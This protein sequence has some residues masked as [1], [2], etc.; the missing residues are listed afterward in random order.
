MKKTQ[1]IQ[2]DFFALYRSSQI[3]KYF[4]STSIAVFFAFVF[5]SSINGWIDTRGLMAS[6]ASVTEAPRLEAD[7]IMK[8]EWEKLVF[9]FWANAKKVD[10]IEFLLLSDP[11]KF[12]SLSSNDSN[13][14][15]TG[16]WEIGT[17]RVSID[18]QGNNIASGMQVATLI[19]GIDAGVPIAIT[20][21]EFI[22]EWQRY[23]LTSKGE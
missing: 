20:D 21:S 9:T 10:R 16:Q 13:V 18:L 17:Y 19:A 22:S 6:V 3:R 15:V 7:L 4:F 2:T 8:R 11:T 12:R 14:T 5:V 1:K 23:S